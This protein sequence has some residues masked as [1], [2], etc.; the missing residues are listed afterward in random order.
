M[1]FKLKK[2]KPRLI[3]SHILLLGGYFILLSDSGRKQETTGNAKHILQT[4]TVDDTSKRKAFL[5][6]ILRLLPTDL[7]ENGTVSNQDKTFKDWLERTGELPPDF[8][9][10]PSIPSLPNPLIIDEGNKNI[11]VKTK[12][13]WQS[14]REW[15]SKELQ[16]YIT[17]TFPAAPGNL[18]VKVLSE[19]MDGLVTLR[20]LELSFGP[21]HKAKLTVELMIPPGKG[22]FPVYLSQWNHRGWAQVAVRRGYVGCVYAGADDKDDTENYTEVWNNQFDFSRIMR[23]AFAASRAIDYLYTLSFIDKE[24]IGLTGHSRNGKLSLWAAAF[25]ERIKAVIPSSG[26]SGGEVPWRFASHKYDVEDIALLSCAQPA[27]LH[28]RLRFFIGRE[29][30]LPVDQNSFMALIAPRGLMLSAAVNEVAANTLGIEQA[31]LETKKVYQFLGAENNLAIRFREGQHGTNANDA[32]AYVDFFDYIFKRTNRK[33][34]NELLSSFNF[35]NWKK[36]SG[37]NINPLKFKEHLPINSQKNEYASTSQWETYKLSIQKKLE[38]ALGDRPVEVT[39]PG[40]KTYTND[41]GGESY[42]GTS[43][44]RPGAT[45]KMG[46][47]AI[48]PYSG[49]GNY[50]YGYLYYPKNKEQEIKSGSIKL[51]AIIYLHEFDYSKGFSSQF[52]DHEIEPFFQELV[53]NGYA[54]FSY[55]MIGFGTRLEEG[56]W[57]YQRYP[58]WSKM[59]SMVA[60]LQSAVTALSNLNFIDNSKISVAGYSLGATVSLY[61]AS[62]DKRI[63]KVVSVCG[64]MPL[65]TPGS[66]GDLGLKAWTHLYGLFPRLGFF[67]GNENRLPF[68][69][70]EILSCVAPRPVLMVAPTMDKDV[71][72]KNIEA[73]V[74]Q[75]KKIY[76]L[77][78]APEKIEVFS[79]NDYNRFSPEMQARI[80]EWLKN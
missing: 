56:K 55:D 33:P 10:M 3:V 57:F 72:L 77:Y 5:K 29:D 52:F 37:E 69:Y 66:I 18:Q 2:I 30:K 79:P 1:K 25:D 67:V 54:V 34:E 11:P 61:T 26:G 70:H 20:M 27:W 22:P 78:A 39:N 68:D 17:G 71:E 21:N 64:Y 51:P 40:P 41:G 53:N 59:G 36:L 23:R 58:H 7:I 32:E 42:F 15:M 73:T 47:M 75:S 4:R 38:W 44:K 12:Q 45:E 63:A 49:F 8:D 43:V 50:L 6:E 19:K 74:K 28:P 24:K 80:I 31:Y 65:R 13:Q 48:S 62:L 16:H 60:D 46:R 14:K 35:E 76:G 9:Q